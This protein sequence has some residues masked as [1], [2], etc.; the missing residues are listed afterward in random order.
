MEYRRILADVPEQ[1]IRVIK[2][3]SKMTKT[4]DTY[5]IGFVEYV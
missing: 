4:L 1:F 5:V 3:D 2:T